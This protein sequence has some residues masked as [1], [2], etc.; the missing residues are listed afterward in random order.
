MSESIEALT[1]HFDAQAVREDFPILSQ[2][3]NGYPLVYLDSAASCQKPSIVIDAISDFYKNDYASVHRGIHAL[4]DRAT[5]AY[6]GARDIVQKHINARRREEIIFVR[7]AT[8]A[9]NLVA[10][11]F[12]R[13]KVKAGDN[14]VISMM[15]HH[16]N[17]V[18][19][20]ML[21]DAVG[22]TLK[23]IPINQQG[24]LLL[25]AYASLI[26]TRTKLVAITHVS[27][28]LGTINPIQNITQIAHEKGIPVL[29]DGAQGV[30]HL[31]I[32]VQALDCDFYVFSGHKVYGPSGIGVLYGRQEILNKMSPYQTGG[33]MINQVSFEKTTFLPAP[34]R[35]EAGTPNITGAYALG[36]A[37]SYLQTLGI[38]HVAAHEQIL[39]SY[40]T[41]ALAK[42]DGLKILGTATHKAS[43]LSFVV[44]GCHA[45]DIGTLLDQ[46]AIAVRTGHHCTM[47]LMNFY[48]VPGSVRLSFAA[49]N[50]HSD[51]DNFCQ[52]LVHVLKMLRD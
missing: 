28:T 20:Q 36:K 2:S 25:D 24:E 52:R 43:V 51:I 15:E 27:N 19:W 31:Q 41:A 38:A 11:S 4:S 14:I 5:D 16:A 13:D 10:S 40:A 7:G 48:Q 42:I 30:P 47:P 1:E 3:M 37:L 39:L 22:A 34:Q 50:T 29:V 23:V 44:D 17:I 35:F 45:H 32:D 49:Y 8:E 18:P 33:A 6:E 9:I 21:A 26:D 46:Y 12:G